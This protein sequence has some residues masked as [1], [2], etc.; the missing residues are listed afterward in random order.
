VRLVGSRRANVLLITVD[1]WRGDCLGVLGHPVV[2]TP[3]LDR[4]AAEGVLFRRHYAQ[5]AP[6]GPSR[7]SLHTGQYLMNHRSILNG[8]PLDARFTNIALEARSAGYDPVL[9]GYTDASPDP[10]VLAASDARLR[11]YE[12]VLPGF[13]AVVDLPEHLAL[14]G[15][16]LRE[17]GYE[18]PENVREMYEPVSDALCA[19]V[20]YGADDTEAAFVTGGILDHVEAR[21]DEPW[22]V[23]AAY[24]RPHPPFVAPEPYNTMYDPAS[25][26]DPVRHPTIAE[27]GAEHPLLGMMVG[28]PGLHGPDDP[29]ELRRLRATY[30]G[31]MS[32]VDAQLGRL[33]DGLREQGSWDD[34][35]VV[36]TSDHGEQLGDHWLTEKLGWFDQSFHVPCIVRDPRSAADG[37]RG[38][39]IDRFTENV[40]LMPTVLEWLGLDAPLQCDGSSLLGFAS[41]A[42]PPSWRGAAHWEWDFRDPIGEL[43][44]RGLGL[45]SDQCTLAVLRDEAG[46]Y[47]HFA[48]MDPI[49]YDLRDDPNELVNRAGDPG[50][51]GD[52]LGYAQRLLSFRMEHADRALTRLLVTPAGVLSGG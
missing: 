18:V 47:V 42:E 23:H 28:I 8:T 33:F 26:P 16:W 19:P 21:D 35:L 29:D 49:F 13:R 50:R 48:G 43:S 34:T 25:V 22:F 14:W 36:L 46:K 45:R 11:T 15:A 41:G 38:S 24:I 6:C 27:E 44:Q 5:A 39:V 3:A 12:G 40:D 17:R 52:V 31:M 4:L 37:T 10:R 7:A 51:A 32:E 20:R 30:F 2:R 1:Q 9:F